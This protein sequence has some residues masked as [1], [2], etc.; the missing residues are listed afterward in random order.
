MSPE[1][2]V[3]ETYIQGFLFMKAVKI[4]MSENSSSKTVKALIIGSVLNALTV[5][6]ATVIASLFLVVSGNLFENAAKFIM[7]VPLIFGG[8]VGGYVGARINKSNGLLIG[9]LSGVI[10]LIIML[11]IGFAKGNADITYMLLLK[12][13]A[14]LLTAAIGGVKG[15]NK[16]EKLKIN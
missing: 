8:Y 15:V 14:I 7:L 13:L 3:T 12:V 11:V 10:I 16:K 6:I 4:N 2:N 5:I 1:Y 9:T